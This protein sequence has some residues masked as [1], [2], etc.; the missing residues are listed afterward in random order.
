MKQEK[1]NKFFA[2]LLVTLVIITGSLIVFFDADDVVA[3]DKNVFRPADLK[4]IDE[5]RMVRKEDTVVLKY[6][7]SY[8]IVN[9]LHRADRNMVQVLFATLQ[10]AE[11]K[12]GV[13]GTMQ[14]SIASAVREQGTRVVLLQAGEEKKEF[15]A[16]GNANKT[17]AYFMTENDNNSY[18]MAIPGYRV[19]VSGI[20]ELNESG[21]R[22]KYVFGFN[23]QNFKSL[24]AEFKA[25]PSEN[26]TVSMKKDYF[27]VNELPATDTTK[28]YNYLDEVARLTVDGYRTEMAGDTSKFEVRI[29]ITDIG[30]KTY[31]LKLFST[32]NQ[33]EVSGI[34]NGEPVYFSA[35]R[36]RALAKGKS[37]FSKRN[38]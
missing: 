33:A 14:D 2:V 26:F 8:W 15:V 10:Q 12:R 3:I 25:R 35:S 19:Y 21:F 36:I 24:S 18:V 5:I 9:D 11:P 6:N 30:R 27:A 17:V 32:D 23:W 7:G 28:L 34:L 4:A 1:K 16:G 29:T 37:F 31:D 20:F 13:S 38:Q 22:D